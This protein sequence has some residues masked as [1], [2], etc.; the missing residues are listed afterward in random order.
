MP[1]LTK[2]IPGEDVCDEEKA[3]NQ[4]AQILKLPFQESL[5]SK[6]QGMLLSGPKQSSVGEHTELS[7]GNTNIDNDDVT[8]E[9]NQLIP[10]QNDILVMATAPVDDKY[11]DNSCNH[12]QNITDI[13]ITKIKLQF[14]P[15]ICP[16]THHVMHMD[17]MGF[18]WPCLGC[19]KA[20][21]ADLEH[22]MFCCGST[23]FGDVQHMLNVDPPDVTSLPIEFIN[24][25]KNCNLLQLHKY[26]DTIA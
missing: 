3:M 19:S 2:S 21:N 22:Q 15:V 24:A 1:M 12:W 6:L 25:C 18:L 14:R 8:I 13:D 10:T 16:L 23:F 11:F 7:D 4:F 5:L 26:S 9:E 17:K 20:T